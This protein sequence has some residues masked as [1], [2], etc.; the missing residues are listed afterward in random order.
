MEQIT[1][2]KTEDLS[3]ENTGKESVQGGQSSGKEM[4]S[5]ITTLNCLSAWSVLQA[6]VYPLGLERAWHLN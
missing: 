5:S 4:P 2:W 1:D 3:T 6:G